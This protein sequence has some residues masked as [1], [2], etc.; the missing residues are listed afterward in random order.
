[1]CRIIAPFSLV[2][3][4]ARRFTKTAAWRESEREK[5]L[6]RKPAVDCSGNHELPSVSSKTLCMELKFPDSKVTMAARVGK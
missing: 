6:I 4:T 1:M 5:N 3:D 2:P